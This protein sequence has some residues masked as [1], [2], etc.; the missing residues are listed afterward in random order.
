M[1]TPAKISDQTIQSTIRQLFAVEISH[2]EFIPEGEISWIYKCRVKSNDFDK[3]VVRISE[4]KPTLAIGSVM[5]QL[6]KQGYEWMPK[7]F[8]TKR[9]SL[10]GQKSD[11]Y[12]SLQQYFDPGKDSHIFQL[13]DQYLEYLGKALRQLHDTKLPIKARLL[14]TRQRFN[15]KWPKLLSAWMSEI[16]KSQLKE[17]AELQNIVLENE[18]ELDALIERFRALGKSLKKQKFPLV[19]THGDVHPNNILRPQSDHLYLI[20]WETV[21]FSHREN[22]L[23]YF[24]DRQLQLISKGYGDDLL[25]NSELIAY[26]R[27]FL[28]IRALYH[29]GC[30]KAHKGKNAAE[31]VAGLQS[32]TE[33]LQGVPDAIS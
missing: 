21:S 11:H 24:D 5:N 9:G 30:K 17:D 29:I 32:F 33:H 10:H 19:L 1:K 4:E 13:K 26:Y 20:D 16:K 3:A 6:T 12:Y 8:V 7:N 18:A 28:L 31:R 14:T 25:K 2:L 27:A 22:D 23:M 15:P